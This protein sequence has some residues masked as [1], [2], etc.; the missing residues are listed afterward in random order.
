MRRR[1]AEHNNLL[2]LTSASLK[3][4]FQ[5]NKMLELFS[6]VLF[7]LFNLGLDYINSQ[8]LLIHPEVLVPK[9]GQPHQKKWP[10]QVIVT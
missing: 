8:R 7:N 3:L 2:L 4:S 6:S 1:H 9:M 5:L 10:K